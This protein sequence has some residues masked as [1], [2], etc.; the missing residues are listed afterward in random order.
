[1]SSFLV[2]ITFILTYIIVKLWSSTKRPSNFPPGPPFLPWIG[3]T[4]HL[5]KESALAGGQHKAYENWSKRYNSNVLGLKLGNDLVVVALTYPLVKQVHLEEVF[6]GRPDTFFFRLRTMGTRKGITGV[7]GPLWYKHRHF[8]MKQLRNVG[9]GRTPMEKYIEKETDRLLTYIE[10]LN[11]LP[12]W[13]GSFLAHVVI[14]VLWTLVAN[15]HFAYEDKRLQKLLDLLHRRSKAFDMSGGLLSQYPWLR[16]IAP[17]KTGYNIICQLNKELHEFFMETIEE[18]RRT[19]TLANAESDFIYAY[20]QEMKQQANKDTPFTETELTMVILD[21]FIAGSQSTSHTI[22]LALMTLALR[23]DIQKNL[24]QEI[25]ENSKDNSL[26]F[27]HLSSKNLYPYMEAFIMEVQRFYHILPITGPRRAMWNTKL[28]GYDIPKDTIVFMSLYTVLMDH[29]HYGDPKTFRPERFM[30]AEGKAFRDDFFMPFGQGRRRCLGDNLAR[31]C[32]FS[33]LLK[34]I[35]NF[36]IKLSD[37]P[38]DNPSMELVPGIMLSPKPYKI[39]LI[40]RN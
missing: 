30:D 27:P 12:V 1:M 5:R 32:L 13:P 18:H 23:Q 8:S 34:I 39:R 36:D 25:K 40:K 17:N 11:G 9:F 38:E 37:K 14:N 15:K 19:L 26:V 31:A 16:F 3:N 2:F 33:F 35:Q 28:N 6:E 21:F 20:L 7:D 24:Y 29:E 10:N 4:M 22:E